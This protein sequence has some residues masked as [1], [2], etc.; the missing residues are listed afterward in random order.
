LAICHSDDVLTRFSGFLWGERDQ[1]VGVIRFR[2][3]TGLRRAASRVPVREKEGVWLT[4]ELSQEGAELPRERV[5]S[6]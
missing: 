5:W 4:K 2:I 6:G 3:Q 1:M